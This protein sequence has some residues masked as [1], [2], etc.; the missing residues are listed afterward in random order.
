MKKLVSCILAGAMALALLA[1]CASTPP[2]TVAT[3]EPEGNAVTVSTV[4][5]LLAAIGSDKEI[6]LAPG[7]YDLTTAKDYGQIPSS[8]AYTWNRISDG[9]EL[10]VAGIQNLTI[11]GSGKDQ[12][13]IVTRPRYANVVSFSDC[14]NLRL[15][16]FTAG[17]TEEKG[18][19][20]TGGVI[21]LE[22]T[23]HVVIDGA[24]LYGCGTM[25]VDGWNCEG[26]QVSNCEIYDCSYS[27]ISFTDTKDITV[28]NTSFHNIGTPEET[29]GDL[30]SFYFCS[31]AVVRNCTI[32]DNAVYHLLDFSSSPNVRLENNRFQ[33]NFVESSGFQFQDCR[34]VLDGNTFQNNS[35][36]K[37]YLGS[38]SLAAD[39]QGNPLDESAFPAAEKVPASTAPQDQIAASTVD[40]FLAAIAPNTEIVLDG[41]L[42]DLSTA[43][44]YGKGKTD[45][46]RWQE[47]FD[48][49][50]LVIQNVDNLTITSSD[51]NHKDHTIA[52]V[53]RYAAV[54]GFEHCRNTLLSGLTA[55]HTQEP[56]SCSGDVI[57]YD[58][59]DNMTIDNCGLYGC[60]VIG[61]SADNCTGLEIL[62]SEIYE[63]SS[64]G[65]EL[66]TT[67]SVLVE[68]TSFHN[69]GTPETSAGNAAYLYG[70]YDV[71]LRSCTFQ[72]NFLY[73]L[74]QADST[75]L[76]LENTTF[77][78]NSTK[79][80]GFRLHDSELILDGSIFQNNNIR[81][82]YRGSNSH[83]K[84]ASGNEL[85][86]SAFPAMKRP[87][88]SSTPQ[89]QVKA[90]TV[91]EL[92]AAIAPNTEIILDAEL[93]DLSTA[94]D[95]GNGQTD[96]YRWQECFDGHELVIQNVE[97]LTIST[98]DGSR[99]D[100]TISAIPRYA[101]VLGFEYCQGVTISGFTAGHTK[102]PGYCTGGVINFDN[103]DNMTVDNCGLYGCGILGV[104]AMNSAGIQVLNSEIYECSYGGIQMIRTSDVSIE[105]T[106]FRDLGGEELMFH[107]CQH[108]TLDGVP[109]P[110]N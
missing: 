18:L 2:S 107:D 59:C 58:S 92:L 16:G 55:G 10:C 110:N 4:D 9:Y 57:Y 36:R 66:S 15:E 65:I 19:M 105:K 27:G 98:S 34:P 96:Y 71:S 49:Y 102:E 40:E 3:A 33:D 61:V 42:Y 85:D 38:Q 68:N 24:G 30:F 26:I 106:T 109:Y 84:D 72:D 97:N 79:E 87:A 1:G 90:S 31:D 8:P 89:K 74:I 53:P 37:W 45:Y 25:G 91:D 103:C 104:Q 35:L 41:A 73:S 93:Y 64:G 70:C 43:T 21:H 28:E 67:D 51:R 17:H 82:W 80:S 81:K 11:R 100:H 6:T 108:V 63:C 69:I 50:E 29:A 22:N 83:A 76:S 95:Y 101:N 5:E 88:P 75:Q 60:G 23:K 7:T 32:Q 62:N 94:K 44:D 52:A 13:S 54:L 39:A 47:C 14:G 78:N 12:A 86:E 56:G 48:G 77:Q 99:K 20:C 46:Y